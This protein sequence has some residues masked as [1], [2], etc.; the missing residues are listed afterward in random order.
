[1]TNQPTDA[2]IKLRRK[3]KTTLLRHYM[4]DTKAVQHLI[5]LDISD[6]SLAALSLIPLVEVAWAD[7][8]ID[9]SEKDAIVRAARSLA[10]AH[11]AATCELL[12]HW[13][14]HKPDRG[15]LD[16]WHEYVG[17]YTQSLGAI[18]R[19]AFKQQVLYCARTVAESAGGILGRGN[20]TSKLERLV[21]EDL[22]QAMPNATDR[23][24]PK[25]TPRLQ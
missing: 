23:S 16:A 18:A 9:Q 10:P 4:H 1:M 24:C 14:T 5:A 7:G 2:G 17:T 12:N 3:L 13:L 25:T 19:D 21:L 11:D 6:E 15:V 20:K 8:N 22:C